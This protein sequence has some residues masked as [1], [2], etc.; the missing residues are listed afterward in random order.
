MCFCPT[1]PPDIYYPRTL[2]IQVLLDA[3]DAVNGVQTQV[4]SI[5]SRET[6]PGIGGE[7]EEFAVGSE[8]ESADGK[9]R[10]SVDD[11]IEVGS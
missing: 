7:G 10:Q 5:R 3:V 2:H 9:G 8:E 4:S 1:P 11:K 6:V